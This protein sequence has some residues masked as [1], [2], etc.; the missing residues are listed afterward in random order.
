MWSVREKYGTTPAKDGIS[1]F[2]MRLG[3]PL[4]SLTVS[5]ANYLHRRYGRGW[6]G[7][8]SRCRRSGVSFGAPSPKLRGVW[9]L[10]CF[11]NSGSGPTSAASPGFVYVQP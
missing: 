2:S 10:M 7:V 8:R 4:C 5:Q 11:W 3:L 6:D 9:R 1:T